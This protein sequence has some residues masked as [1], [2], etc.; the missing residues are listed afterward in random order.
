MKE[1][2]KKAHMQAAFVYAAL[3]CCKRKQVGCVIVKDDTPIAV[4]YNGTPSGEENICEDD[5]G[6]TK[7]NV[8][9]AEDNALRKLTRSHESSVDAHVFVTAAPCIRCAEKLKDAKVKKVYYAE[10]YGN[11]TDGLAYLEQHG[12]ETELVEQ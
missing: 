9:H 5:S 10:V 12:I 1:K 7:P 4:G 6:F 2:F 3:S 8:I 11:H